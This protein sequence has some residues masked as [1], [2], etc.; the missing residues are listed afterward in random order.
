[1]KCK[2]RSTLDDAIQNWINENCETE[3]WPNGSFAISSLSEHMASAAAA[4]FDISVECRREFDEELE[5][6]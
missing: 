2:L 3:H 5:D 6:D 4:V 1:M